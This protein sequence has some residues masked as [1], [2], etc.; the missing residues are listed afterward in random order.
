[1]Y[2][3]SSAGGYLCCFYF[4]DTVI[5]VVMNMNIQISVQSLFSIILGIYLEVGLL[6]HTEILSLIA[7]ESPYCFPW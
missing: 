5:N 3:H 6:G 1:M 2:I 7:E 4:L